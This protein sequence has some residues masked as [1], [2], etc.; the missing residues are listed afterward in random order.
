MKK[1]IK[2]YKKFQLIRLLEEEIIKRYS[3]G[4]MRCPTHISIGQEAIAVAFSEVS[5]KTVSP[6]VS[7]VLP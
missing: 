2:I 3:E 6:I 4:K 7:V 5:V 1:I